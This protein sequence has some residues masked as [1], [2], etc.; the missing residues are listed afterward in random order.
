MPYLAQ[1]FFGHSK[2]KLK[3]KKTQNSRGKLKLKLKTQIFGIFTGF[4]QGKSQLGR[5][6]LTSASSAA[7]DI[8]ALL[9]FAVFY[10]LL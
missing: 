2:K 8:F 7:G 3:A 4:P 9:C 1:A 6:K 5:G 10:A